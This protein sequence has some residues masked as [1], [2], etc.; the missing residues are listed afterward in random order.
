MPGIQ[1]PPLLIQLVAQTLSL[2]KPAPISVGQS[3][4]IESQS[5]LRVTE[6]TSHANVEDE[7]AG[8]QAVCEIHAVLRYEYH[9]L[10]SCSYQIPVLYFRASTLDG[11][12]LSLEE[13]WSNVHSNYRQRLRHGPWDTLTQQVTCV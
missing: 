4:V 2:I 9:V 5:R 8:V 3:D 6:I 11:R 10:Y 12:P 7:T 13:V 1:T